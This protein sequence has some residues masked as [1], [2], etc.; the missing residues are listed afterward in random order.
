[1]ARTEPGAYGDEFKKQ[2]AA[3]VYD[4]IEKSWKEK[5]DRVFTADKV[6]TSS[7]NRQLKELAAEVKWKGN[8]IFVYNSL[9]WQRDGLVTLHASS[10]GIRAMLL[11]ILKQG[12]S[13][14]SPMKKILFNLL[15]KIFLHPAI[16]IM[17]L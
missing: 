4:D 5:S 14:R 7:L 13:F 10:I 8:R 1:M 3:G 15:P 12:R 17:Y 6:V 11:R 2:R 16:A 9:P